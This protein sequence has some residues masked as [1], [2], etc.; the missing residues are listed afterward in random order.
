MVIRKLRPED[1]RFAVSRIYEESWKTAYK[2]IVPQNFL[3]SIEPGRW[4]AH[5]DNGQIHHLLLIEDGAF[6]GTASY[7]ESR[8]PA[9]AGFGEIVSI[10]LLPEYMGRGLGKKLFETV[11]ERLQKMVSTI[12]FYGYWRKI[13]GQENFMRKWDLRPAENFSMMISEE[14]SFERCSTSDVY[15][16]TKRLLS[17][18]PMGV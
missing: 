16:Y 2:N 1:D 10:Y 15:E 17:E 13:T 6:I 5:L 18:A 11:V 3:D 14:S 8:L 9:F 7:C 4:A 12:S